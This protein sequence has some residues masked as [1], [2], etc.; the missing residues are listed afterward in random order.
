M[1]T[2]SGETIPAE[3]ARARE[4]FLALVAEIRPELHRYCARL[5][6]SAVQGEDIVQETLAKTFYAMSMATEVPSLRPWL[7][8]VAHN[9]AIDFMRR[10]DQRHVEVRGDFEETPEEIEPSD[11]VATRAALSTFLELPPRQRCAVI[12]KD[13]LGHSL[14]ETADTM[15]ASVQAVKAALVRGRGALRAA[16]PRVSKP[17]VDPQHHQKLE[18]YAALFNARDWEG[19]RA[20][21]G[22]ECRL[23]LVTKAARTGRGVQQYYDRYAAGPVRVAVGTV[24][25]RPALLAFATDDPRPSYFITLEWDGARLAFIRDYRYVDYIVDDLEYTLS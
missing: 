13:V 5:V 11:P 20:L 4:Q 24:E 18:H 22:E 7:F 23:D 12:L 14:E 1:N 2:V 21:V 19:L 3:F 10:Y 8:R 6:G 9:T 16:E 17:A 25:G 15:G